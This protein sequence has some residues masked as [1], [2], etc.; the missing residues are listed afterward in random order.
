MKITLDF[1]M[2]RHQ[3]TDQARGQRAPDNLDAW[4]LGSSIASLASA[5]HLIRDANVPAS[6]IHIL[7]S[8]SVPGDGLISI[9]DPLNGYDHRTGCMPSFND[10]CMEELLSLVPS[11]TGS[12]RTALEDMKEFDANETCKDV[13][14]T[15]LLIQGE[16]GLERV[17]T[18][19]LSMGLKDRINLVILILKT[20]ESLGRKRVSELFGKSFFKSRF[21][22]VLSTMYVV[23]QDQLR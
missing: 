7:E 8:H 23:Q 17:E 2:T 13:A 12:G 1:T 22:A 5:V 4:I 6:R 15:H 18:R 3:Q 20:E 19:N 16:H 11:A 21:W 10:V 14:G 9:G